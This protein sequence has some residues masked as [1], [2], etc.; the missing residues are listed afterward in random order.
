[1]PEG[2]NIGINFGKIAGAGLGEHMHMHIVPRWAGDAS[3]ITV[4]G[5]ARVI[6]EHLA[7]TYDMLAEI[8]RAKQRNEA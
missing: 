8:F 7:K 6:P 4:V 2:F 3:F 5:E 1:M